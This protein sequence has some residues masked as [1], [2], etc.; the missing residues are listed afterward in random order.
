M[1]EEEYDDNVNNSNDMNNSNIIGL[2]HTEVVT[3]MH[4]PSRKYSSDM[5]MEGHFHENM[6]MDVKIN[7]NTAG[8]EDDD[9]ILRRRRERSQ[10]GSP[11]TLSS[12]GF[13]M[14]QDQDLTGHAVVSNDHSSSGQRNSF[15]MGGGGGGV[16]DNWGWFEDDSTEGSL[17]KR[18]HKLLDFSTMEMLPLNDSTDRKKPEASTVTAP[19]YVLEESRSSQKLWKDTAGNRPPQPVEERAMYEKLWTENFDKSKV[20]YNMPEDVL[21]STTPIAV[22]PFTDTTYD[23]DNDIDPHSLTAIN[24]LSNRLSSRH[25]DQLHILKAA[26][27]DAMEASIH[28]L[29]NKKNKKP[30]GNEIIRSALT[31]KE[32]EKFTVFMRGDNV[33]GTTVSKAF[34]V[35]DSNKVESFSVSID[36]YRVI[37]VRSGEHHCYYFDNLYFSF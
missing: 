5:E 29:N 25:H 4:A 18:K 13:R 31:K 12:D 35:K 10:E 34:P 1:D 33:F 2:E 23:S 7:M 36:K 8:I 27:A 16:V 21:K 17:A 30:R 20:Q 19:K 24:A 15:M 3:A 37:E 6:D 9:L 14:D 26:E 22:C 11:S 32:A 28:Q